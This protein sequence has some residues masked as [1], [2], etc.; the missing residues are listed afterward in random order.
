MHLLLNVFLARAKK[1]SITLKLKKACFEGK[2]ATYT[3]NKQIKTLTMNVTYPHRP[4]MIVYHVDSLWLFNSFFL[5]MVMGGNIC[6]GQTDDVRVGAEAA[7]AVKMKVSWER[8]PFLSYDCAITEQWVPVSASSLIA[9]FLC[10]THNSLSAVLAISQQCWWSKIHTQSKHYEP[11]HNFKIYRF[12]YYILWKPYFG[13][14]QVSFP[15]ILNLLY[16]H[17]N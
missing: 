4:L 2:S 6:T 1:T 13:S 10:S 11:Q 8:T 7:N 15:Y 5:N 12:L 9:R 14:G 3:K 17:Y 16:T